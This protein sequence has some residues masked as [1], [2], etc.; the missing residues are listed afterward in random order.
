MADIR[1]VQEGYVAD[2]YV[3]ITFDVSL[4]LT[5]SATV[6]ATGGTIQP[7]S[8]NLICNQSG[9]TWAEMGTW[10]EPKQEYWGPNFTVEGEVI[11]GGSINTTANSTFTASALITARPVIE[12]T[13]VLQSTITVNLIGSGII[14]PLGSAQLTAVAELIAKSTANLSAQSTLTAD[15]DLKS[16]GIIL[17]LGSG[18][19]NAQAIITAQGTASMVGAGTMATDGDAF[20]RTS[21]SFQPQ[22]T[23]SC[24]GIIAI[25]GRAVMQSGSSLGVDNAGIFI[26][27]RSPVNITAQASWNIVA[28]ILAESGA[29]LGG[30]TSTLV[31]GSKFA[32]DPYRVYTV[33]TESRINI[34]Q[35]ET[36]SYLVPSETRIYKVQHLKLVD[37]LG[38]LDRREG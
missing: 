17:Q 5:A 13:G 25:G 30:V 28:G 36:R 18:S 1:Y 35:Q 24:D 9:L 12:F 4:S 19:L 29:N 37:E 15:P 8:A 31:V 22:C 20:L 27:R 38:I 33:P 11:I 16:E 26:T 6:T 32:I 21:A 10:A 34:L 23:V 2:S 14:L 7:A 3:E